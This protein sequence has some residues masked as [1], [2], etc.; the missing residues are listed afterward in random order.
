MNYSGYKEYA[1]ELKSLNLN[2]ITTAQIN[3]NYS[4]ALINTIL[5][6]DHIKKLHNSIP[7]ILW[8]HEGMTVIYN[9]KLTPR[10]LINILSIPKTLIFQTPWQSEAV[11]K[12]FIHQLPKEKI[13]CIPI[14][15]GKQNNTKINKEKNNKIQ[16][17]TLGSVYSRKRPLDLAKATINVAQR[18]NVQCNFIGDLSH[19]GTLG[20]E[21]E[22]YL[23]KYTTILKWN[24]ILPTNNKIELI[25]SSDIACFPSGD[26]TF[27]ISAMETA[28]LKTPL[29]LADL[30]VYNHIGWVDGKNCLKYPVGNIKA[31]ETSIEKLILNPNLRTSLAEEAIKLVE[32][33]PLE[34]FFQ[35]IT[36]TVISS[37]FPKPISGSIDFFQQK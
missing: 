8:I 24:G 21:A 16:I 19:T 5:D 7:I 31:L 3:N 13:A 35:Q 22:K 23:N 1:T 34:H 32:N 18:H 25:A 2:P 29:I 37:I 36:D 9:M 12:S 4:F 10:E 28:A 15:I 33:Y 30:E 11:F 17:T 14:G 27:N 20:P 26:E 6:I